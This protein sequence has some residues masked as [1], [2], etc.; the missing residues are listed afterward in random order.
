MM[1]LSLEEAFQRFDAENSQDPHKE[2]VK[3][4]AYPQA[5]L[6]SQRLNSWILK[7]QPNASPHLLLAARCQHICRWH[8]PRKNYPMTRQGYLKWRAD[9]QAFHARKS[10]EIL[11][12]LGYPM[13]LIQKVQDLNLKKNFPEDPESLVLEDALCLVFLE[14]HFSDFSV[15]MDESKVIHILKKTWAK[16]SSRGRIQALKIAFQPREKA[17]V[18]K[19]LEI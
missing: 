12:Q 17:L 18:E 13:D 7:L 8:I 19:A 4:V 6:D 11:C 9:L 16:M 2:K 10:G 14:F 1:F 3:G 15:R 5:L